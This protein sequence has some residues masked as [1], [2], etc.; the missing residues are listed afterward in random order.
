MTGIL[1]AV[2]GFVAAFG[3]HVRDAAVGVMLWL[4][5]AAV[6]LTAFIPDHVPFAWPDLAGLGVIIRPL[7][8]INRFVHLPVLFAVIGFTF[9][10]VAGKLAYAVIRLIYGFVPFMK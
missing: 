7:G 1:S 2:V 4:V 6:A 8:T 10:F 3:G 9:T 5:Q